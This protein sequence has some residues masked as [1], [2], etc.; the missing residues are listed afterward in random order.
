MTGT[1]RAQKGAAAVAAA[2]AVNY[3]GAGTV[4][5]I[6][7]QRA[8]AVLGGV[9]SGYRGQVMRARGEGASAAAL[10]WKIWNEGKGL[11]Q[12]SQRNVIICRATTYPSRAA[13]GSG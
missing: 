7:E 4:E 9:G 5:F 6:V 8:N 10:P 11:S 1:L 2:R 13:A 12:F 3:V